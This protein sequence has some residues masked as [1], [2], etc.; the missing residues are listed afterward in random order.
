MYSSKNVTKGSIVCIKRGITV[1]SEFLGFT[2]YDIENIRSISGAPY[3]LDRDLSVLGYG[4][5]VQDPVDPEKVNC[6]YSETFENG[7]VAVKATQDVKAGQEFL[8]SFGRLWWSYYY[9]F[10]WNINPD[11]MN[12]LQRKVKQVYGIDESIASWIYELSSSSKAIANNVDQFNDWNFGI[13]NSVNNLIN[14]GH[15]CYMAVCFQCMSHIPAL[16]RLLLETDIGQNLDENTFLS[17]YIKLLTLLIHKDKQDSA[18][19]QSQL[20]YFSDNRQQIDSK[21]KPNTDQDALEFFQA[22]LVKFS[23]ECSSFEH[24]KHHLFCIYVDVRTELLDCD[25]FSVTRNTEY[26]LSLSFEGPQTSGSLQPTR[27][28]KESKENKVEKITTLEDMISFNLGKE[29]IQFRCPGCNVMKNAVQSRIVHKYPRV[30]V[31]HL[32]RFSFSSKSTLISTKV[33]YKR[34]MTL[35]EGKNKKEV[36]YELISLIVFSGSATD[37]GG[38]YIAYVLNSDKKW[39][40]LDDVSDRR[41][42]VVEEV[43]AKIVVDQ[44]L[45]FILFYKKCKNKDSIMRD[46][47]DMIMDCYGKDE[48]GKIAVALQIK[49]G[50]LSNGQ[51]NEE[52]KQVIRRFVEGKIDNLDDFRDFIKNHRYQLHLWRY[53]NKDVEQED[54]IYN[55]CVPNGACGFQVDFLIRE[56]TQYNQTSAKEKD[57]Y[58][59][60]GKHHITTSK[61]MEAFLIYLNTILTTPKHYFSSVKKPIIDATIKKSNGNTNRYKSYDDWIYIRTKMRQAERLDYKTWFDELSYYKFYH[62]EKWLKEIN[63]DFIKDYYPS[64]KRIV[65]QEIPLWYSMEMFNYTKQNRQFCIFFDSSNQHSVPYIPNHYILSY[66]TKQGD[67]GKDCEPKYSFHEDEVEYCLDVE[68]HSLLDHNHFYL[69]PTRSFSRNV[70]SE[71]LTDYFESIN[72]ILKYGEFLYP[73]YEPLNRWGGL[74]ECKRSYKIYPPTSEIDSSEKPLASIFTKP[75]GKPLQL[76]DMST[77]EKEYDVV[78]GPKIKA[79]L[80]A[81]KAQGISSCTS[82][83]FDLTTTGAETEQEIETRDLME[84]YMADE[85][86]TAATGMCVA[87][88]PPPPQ[89]VTEEKD[90]VINLFKTLLPNVLF[91]LKDKSYVHPLKFQTINL[92]KGY[93]DNNKGNI[94]NNSILYPILSPD[95][96]IDL[97]ASSVEQNE[98]NSKSPN[99]KRK[100][101]VVKQ[102]GSP[103]KK[104]PKQSKK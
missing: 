67:D 42:N 94:N 24:V 1:T 96:V 89:D 11:Q 18:T 36:Y 84:A 16:S 44:D 27:K 25:H 104:S 81:D 46:R 12:P 77:D 10:D 74:T 63:R 85:A 98:E 7:Y 103:N 87:S 100:L 61:V 43:S 51:P 6:E 80:L 21:F 8:V 59:Y 72:H 9:R 52:S 82:M 29:D 41:K 35:L 48:E 62:V 92:L 32:K 34:Y 88:P 39:Y 76:V 53:H 66:I 50:G 26:L 33:E 22:I 14:I 5:Y 70:L 23:S 97:T 99:K 37:G 83:A 49:T 75:T 3:L 95:S 15:S 38:H 91:M 69:L 79:G 58:I 86:L 47:I 71:G 20:K 55:S 17:R 93:Y 101:T 57:Y 64:S 30:L 40:K 28:C 68:N 90:R 45:P 4:D 2:D 102:E 54:L 56:R 31:I 73:D 19:I 13:V 65:D 60:S 78:M